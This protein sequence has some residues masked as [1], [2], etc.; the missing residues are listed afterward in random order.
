MPKLTPQLTRLGLRLTAVL[1]V[2]G[3]LYAAPA[4]SHGQ[5]LPL[6]AEP[7]TITGQRH[8]DA[9]TSGPQDDAS[10]TNRR[11]NGDESTPDSD[12]DS[13]PSRYQEK[14]TVKPS[15]IPRM[16]EPLLFDL[17]RPLGAERGELEVNTL[18]RPPVGRRG[19]SV[20]WAPEIEFA[21]APGHTVEF[22]LP[23]EDGQLEAFKFGLQ[24]TL[25]TFRQHRSIHGW[26]ALVE[27][28]RLGRDLQL[29][30]LHLAGH[31]I[32]QRWSVFT[33][34]GA[35][36]KRTAQQRAVKGVFNPTVFREVSDR[37]VLGLETNL[38]LGARRRADWVVLPQT[39]VEWR[40]YSFQFGLGVERTLPH[41]IRPTMAIRLIRTLGS[42]G[43]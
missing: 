19:Q 31:R 22:E 24:G 7:P 5:H 30:M 11:S 39:H 43:H 21:F 18:L 33:M 38:A 14:V 26:Q 32:G 27:R 20:T 17:M 37:L 13:A 9:R 10:E 29:D 3:G 40:R 34:Q 36:F 42:A 6:V 8:R 25:G 4:I 12:L 35:R 28:A 2:Y 16:P 15:H 41:G 1:T 23:F